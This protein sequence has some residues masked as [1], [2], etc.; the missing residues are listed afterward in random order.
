MNA[1]TSSSIRPKVTVLSPGQIEQIH[2]AALHILATVGVRVDAPQARQVFIQAGAQTDDDE[3]VR[4]PA[5][6]IDWALKAAPS[7]VE[8]YDRRGDRAFSLGASGNQAPQTRFGIGVTSL[9]YQDPETD[10]VTPFARQHMEKMVRLGDALDSFDVIANPGVIQDVT[11]ERSDLIAAL[12][13]MANTIKP[14]V[15]LVSDEERFVDVL[16]MMEHLHGDLAVR[17]FVIPY[18]NPITPLVMNRGT[19]DK[20]RVTIQRGLPF[21]YSNYGM[22]GATTPITPVSA[23][24]LLNAEL[25]AG[26]TLS[27][28]YREGAPVILGNLPAYFDM[29]GMGSFYDAHSYII[30]LA[31]AEMMAHYGLPHCGTS[32]SGM[33]WGADLIASGHQWTNH[34]LSCMG[35]VGLAPFVGDNLESKAFSPTIVVYADE[36][37]AQARR[38]AQGF[39]LDEDALALDEITEAGP[40]GSFLTSKLTLQRFRQAYYQSATWPILTLEDWQARGRP[41]SEDM[42]RQ[43]TRMLLEQAIVPVDHAELITQGEA[44]I[45]ALDA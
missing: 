44:F 23:F 21:I 4:L 15:L 5:E 6:L 32:G 1:S 40:G 10:D 39:V 7:R 3:R 38:L 30:D 29:K 28:L 20:M 26:L 33:G 25:L 17:P 16:D 9:Y 31:C 18:F 8:I 22:V 45:T 41:R 42:L 43:R 19:V 27:Q 14:L 11:P 24:A 35:K 2:A 37:I 13:M 36:I 34:L 12:E